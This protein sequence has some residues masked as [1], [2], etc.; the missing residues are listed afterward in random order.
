MSDRADEKPIGLSGITRDRRVLIIGGVAGG[1]SCAAR[2]RRLDESVAIVVFDRGPYVA[3]ANCGLPYYVGDVIVDHITPSDG[4]IGWTPQQL[5]PP[6]TQGDKQERIYL[7][8]GPHGGEYALVE[9]RTFR[10]FT[11]QLILRRRHTTP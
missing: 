1:A 4:T 5:K 11:Y 6:I 3:F 7:L 2:L 10:P 8:V 9:I